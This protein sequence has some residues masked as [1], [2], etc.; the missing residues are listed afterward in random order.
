MSKNVSWTYL[1][2]LITSGMVL[3]HTLDEVQ[4]RHK[5]PY[6]IWIASKHNV[7]E[8]DVVVGLHMAGRY[9]GEGRLR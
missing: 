9:S 6:S 2:I 1:I 7:T 4:D 5:S 3:L 8:A